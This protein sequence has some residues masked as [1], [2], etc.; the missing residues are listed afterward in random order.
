MLA[1]SAGVTLA[2]YAAAY[3]TQNLA[4]IFLSAL[5]PVLVMLGASLLLSSVMGS[6]WM[7]MGLLIAYWFM[8]YNTRGAYTGVF[9]LFNSAMPMPGIDLDTNRALLLG[10]GGLLLL[11]A[12]WWYG[13][14]RSRG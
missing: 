13:W 10:A 11:A 4:D 9:F 2:I 14:R 1:I 3:E 12:V 8:E 7:S 5:P 6:A